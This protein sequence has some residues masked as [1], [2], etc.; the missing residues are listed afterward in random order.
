MKLV[1]LALILLVIAVA[2]GG[3]YYFQYPEERPANFWEAIEKARSGTA[4]AVEK[5]KEALET[6]REVVGKGKEA[7]EKSKEMVGQRA[8]QGSGPCR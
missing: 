1:K 7:I 2:I 8:R 3:Y 6:G 4:Q 5:G